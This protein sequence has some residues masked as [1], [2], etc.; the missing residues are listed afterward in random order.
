M[1]AFDTT[2]A[3]TSGRGTVL[4]T[5][6]TI[7][8]APFRMIGNALISLAESSSRM[9]LVRQLNDTTDEQLA[10]AG[11]TRADEIRRI[12]ASCGAM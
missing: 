4:A 3:Q 6:W 8:S 1:A 11:T 5:I 10:A 7:F 2:V 12:F 9:E